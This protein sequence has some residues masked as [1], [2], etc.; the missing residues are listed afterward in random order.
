MFTIKPKIEVECY[1]C[2]IIFFKNI[3]RYKESVKRNWKIYCSKSCAYQNRKKEIKVICENPACK[4]H[5]IKKIKEIKKTNSSYCSRHCAIKVNN[6]K[7]PKRKAKIKQCLNCKK[8]FSGENK[9][10]GYYCRK[11]HLNNQLITKNKILSDIRDFYQKNKRIPFKR[12]FSHYVAAQNRF[13]TWNKAII[14]AGFNPNPVMFANKHVANDGH[15]CDSL[16]EKII[17]DFLYKNNVSHEL[18][19][20]YDNNK[21][22]ADFKIKDWLIEFVGLEGNSKIYDKALKRK[23]DWISAQKL[24]VKEIY[25]SDLF[26]INK[27]GAIIK[28]LI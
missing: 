27:L 8:E 22:V 9:C 26:P 4:K 20:P 13:G 16:S 17:D 21:M 23:R 7:F 18:H 12:E 3:Y 14:A 1:H 15:I 5:F 25:P 11:K 19:T 28:E 6:K 10:C 24:K 2:K